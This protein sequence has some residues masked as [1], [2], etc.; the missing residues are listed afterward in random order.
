MTGAEQRQYA[1]DHGV[2]ASDVAA[3]EEKARRR[4]TE[5]GWKP[6]DPAAF[7]GDKQPNK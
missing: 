1:L 5:G 3:W 4:M 7:W 6:D 2:A